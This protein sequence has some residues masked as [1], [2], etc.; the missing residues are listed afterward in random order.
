MGERRLERIEA[1]MEKF[2][3]A[4]A[5]KFIGGD[6]IAAMDD[7][8]DELTEQEQRLTRLEKET[9]G[10]CYGGDDGE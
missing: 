1:A 5:A 2:R 4:A 10:E 6:A 9:L 7:I 8:V 3:K